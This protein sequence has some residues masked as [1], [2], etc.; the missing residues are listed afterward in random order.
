MRGAYL[1]HR[2]AEAIVL[3]VVL[4]ILNVVSPQDADFT[5]AVVLLPL[6]EV[7][8][9]EELP[10]VVPELSHTGAHPTYIVRKYAQVMMSVVGASLASLVAALAAVVHED[11]SCSRAD[12][13]GSFVVSAHRPEDPGPAPAIVVFGHGKLIPP[14]KYAWLT[15]HLVNEGYV[16]ALPRTMRLFLSHQRFADDLYDALG[17]TRSWLGAA[18]V[19][20]AGDG[21]AVIAGHSMGG[22]AAA[23]AL[24]QHNDAFAAYIGLAPAETWPSA[25]AAAANIT[26]P[27]LLVTGTYDWVTP[28]PR[29]GSRILAAMATPDASKT[30]DVIANGSHCQFC[31]PQDGVCNVMEA[32]SAAFRPRGWVAGDKQRAAT[33][34]DVDAFLARTFAGVEAPVEADDEVEAALA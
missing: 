11:V 20:L 23:L 25:V 17:C 27:A 31:A 16:V 14:S 33:L 12:G 5:Q 15:E 6:Q 24:G 32:L 28:A 2:A 21:G 8:L 26:R 18:G 3:V 7:H 30:H 1:G 9:L 13:K 29:H 22:G 4:A 34:G 10:L 19:F